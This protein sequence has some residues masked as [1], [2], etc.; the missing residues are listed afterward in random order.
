[1]EQDG[2]PPFQVSGMLPLVKSQYVATLSSY[3][4]QVLQSIT[5]FVLLLCDR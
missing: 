2:P 4:T 1:M 5:D 3:Y